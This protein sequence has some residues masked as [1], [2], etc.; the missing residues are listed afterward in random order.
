MA[1]LVLPSRLELKRPEGSSNEATFAKVIFTT[2]LYVSPVQMIPACD[3]TGTPRHF[4]SSTTS[5]SAC[6]MRSRTR[7]SVSPRQSPSSLILASISREGES[8]PVPSVEPR[9][10]IV[11]VAFFKVIPNLAPPRRSHS[12]AGQL[13]GLLHPG[14]ELSFVGLVVLMNVDVTRILALGLAG[15]NRT[16]RRAA[17]ESHLDVFREAMDAEEPA[18]ALDSVQRRVPFNR[19]VH[20]GDGAHN[21][22]V[23]AAPDLAFPPWHGRDVGLH[24]SV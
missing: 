5:G 22:R 4:H 6:L 10:F 16:Q 24:A 14:G 18:L 17:E 12:F 2:V 21:E 19:L 13:A 23:E 7:A 15:G 8:P 1:R 11:V 20:A 9:F 3:H